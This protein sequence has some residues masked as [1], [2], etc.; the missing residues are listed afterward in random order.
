[1][2][3]FRVKNKVI[4]DVIV[5][6]E[7]WQKSFPPDSGYFTEDQL[8]GSLVIGAKQQKDGSFTVAN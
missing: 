5:V 6:D 8:K 7:N 4:V 1:M 3:L 2:N